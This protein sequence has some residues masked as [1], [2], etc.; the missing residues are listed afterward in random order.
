M[1]K[2]I[3]EKDIDKTTMSEIVNAI[4][5]GKIVVFRTD[6]VY[7]IGTNALDKNAVKKFM[8]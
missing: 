2:Y 6:T 7:G 5:K 4:R 8:K 3:K 1:T